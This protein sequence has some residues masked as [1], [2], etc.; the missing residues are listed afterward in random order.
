[1]PRWG[2]AVTA[3]RWHGAGL[4]AR[5]AQ[6]EPS[7]CVFGVPRW[8]NAWMRKTVLIML[9]SLADRMCCRL[10]RG[11]G[12]EFSGQRRWDEFFQGL[13]GFCGMARRRTQT[14]PRGH[15]SDRSGAVVPL[16]RRRRSRRSLTPPRTAHRPLPRSAVNA[17]SHWVVDVVRGPT[18]VGCA[19]GPKCS[20]EPRCLGRRRIAL[21]S[22]R[23]PIGRA[24]AQHTVGDEHF[25]GW[26]DRLFAKSKPLGALLLSNFERCGSWARAVTAAFSLHARRRH[27]LHERV[28]AAV[29]Q[30]G[31][32]RSRGR[33]VCQGA[34]VLVRA[35]LP[36][37]QGAL[38]KPPTWLKRCV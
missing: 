11:R 33:L 21:A 37:Q 18:I 1:M 35:G 22:G 15:A 4:V 25:T 8:R 23:R 30:R 17:T 3:T 13:P 34:G 32:L 6:H 31:D 19:W 7:R 24:C 2:S 16:A 27:Q 5:L 10:N 28:V 38:L 36:G 26:G 29:L 14:Q 9:H 20:N 12:H